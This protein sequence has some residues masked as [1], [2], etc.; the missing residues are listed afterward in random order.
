MEGSLVQIK[1]SEIESEE[2]SIIPLLPRTLLWDLM[3][4]PVERIELDEY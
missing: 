1:V 2:L 3:H 4:M